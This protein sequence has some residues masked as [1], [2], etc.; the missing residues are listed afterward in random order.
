MQY[1]FKIDGEKAQAFAKIINKK[2][3]ED[4]LYLFSLGGNIA[5]F[6][7]STGGSAIGFPVVCTTGDDYNEKNFTLCNAK[8]WFSL[9]AQLGKD[10][11]LVIDSDNYYF[12]DSDGSVYKDCL[13]AAEAWQD[14]IKPLASE[15]VQ[16]DIIARFKL[17]KKLR[18][19]KVGVFD[20]A[21]KRIGIYIGRT[22]NADEFEGVELDTLDVTE[23][24][25]LFTMGG[26]NFTVQPWKTGLDAE[27]LNC[28]IN[29]KTYLM[30]YSINGFTVIAMPY[31]KNEDARRYENVFGEK[32]Q[33]P[34]E[35]PQPAQK[36]EPK[37]VISVAVEQPQP[38][39]VDPYQPG[40][41]ES[42]VEQKKEYNPG[43][44]EFPENPEKRHSWGYY[45]DED[46]ERNYVI[47]G[48]EVD[49]HYSQVVESN[50]IRCLSVPVV[51]GGG[52]YILEMKD[53]R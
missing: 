29:T 20:L 36:T 9:A 48:E 5:A 31:N 35:Q 17:P 4:R 42:F 51:E 32:Y 47:D 22:K 30:R 37:E 39:A 3:F 45:Y 2:A 49:P 21:K 1:S 44:P 27:L 46:T 25:Q 15:F 52:Y 12:T 50:G 53:N 40:S 19:G 41:G 23:G 14:G 10:V 13:C 34:T 26:D 7:A 28:H 18:K 38:K 11:T 33:P 43:F 16:T 24:N 8:R 6:F